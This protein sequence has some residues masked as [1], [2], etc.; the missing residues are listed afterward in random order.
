MLN[1]SERSQ[2]IEAGVK[3][4]PGGEEVASLIRF[5]CRLV[6]VAFKDRIF[7]FARKK[8]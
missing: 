6:W 3:A 8:L 5:A 1:L 4:T 7:N 2:E